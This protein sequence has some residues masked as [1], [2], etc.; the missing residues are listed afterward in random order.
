MPVLTT[1]K[2]RGVVS[3]HSP[4]AAGIV[5]GGTIEE[6]I[7]A[8]ADLVIGVGLDPVEL[9]PAPWSHPAPVVLVG[10]WPIDDSTYFGDR[11]LVDVAGDVEELL[12]P[13]VGRL[14][15]TWAEPAAADARAAAQHRLW[16]ASP[17]VPDGVSPHEVVRIARAAAPDGTVATIDAGAHMLVAVPLWEVD[18]PGELLIS[19]GLATMGFALPAAAAAALVHP[20]RRV[21]CFT[22]DGGLG[23]VVAELETLARLR[24]DV[25][26]IVFDDR[27]L[28]LIAIKQHAEGHGGEGA[29][30]YAPTDWAAIAEGFGVAAYRA[31]STAEYERATA[32]ALGR[33]GPA[34]IDVAVD[35]SGYGAVLDAIRG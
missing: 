15:S 4:H 31:D 34:L 24:L 5:T 16:A 32:S 21:V 7:L 9:I 27:A 17:V 8:Q 33:R 19:S 20:D 14:H 11:L 28:S 26:V 29:I 3:D 12:A 30:R 23:M 35:P 10:S 22:G 13:L 6:P 2:A 1:Y 25:T 18:Q